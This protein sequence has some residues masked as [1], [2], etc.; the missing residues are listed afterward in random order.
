MSEMHF[1]QIPLKVA[2]QRALRR[3]ALAP[4]N[5]HCET[6]HASGFFLA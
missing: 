6:R 3:G 2:E 1:E 5:R 4:W